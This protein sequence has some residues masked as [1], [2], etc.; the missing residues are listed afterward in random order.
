MRIATAIARKPRG[1][2]RMDVVTIA[3]VAVPELTLGQNGCQRR[4]PSAKYFKIYHLPGG[5]DEFGPDL[6]HLHDLLLQT[7]VGGRDYEEVD[8][9]SGRG[10]GRGLAGPLDAM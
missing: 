2:E 8:S 9:R 7:R 10:A 3:R 6:P 4:P 5:C 1:K